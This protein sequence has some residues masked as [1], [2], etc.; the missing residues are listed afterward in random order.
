MADWIDMSDAEVVQNEDAMNARQVAFAQTF[1]ASQ[2]GQ[3]VMN[4][5]ERYYADYP[6]TQESAIAKL[7]IREFLDYI[8]N[9]CGLGDRASVIEAEAKLVI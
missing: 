1:Y 4:A 9:C 6:V 3:D 8:R 2:N 7:A 5:M